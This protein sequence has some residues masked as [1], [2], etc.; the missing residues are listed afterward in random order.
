MI[1]FIKTFMY[2]W[3]DYPNFKRFVSKQPKDFIK[4]LEA[5]DRERGIKPYKNRFNF[6]FRNAYMCCKG[7]G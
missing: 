3:E 5:S 6:A 1:K 2:Y 4:R 7:E